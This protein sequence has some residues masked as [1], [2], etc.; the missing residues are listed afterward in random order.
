MMNA[1]DKSGSGGRTS[2]WRIRDLIDLEYFLHA[3]TAVNGL[4]NG[5]VSFPEAR[6]IYI[7]RLQHLGDGGSMASRRRLIRHW[8]D[9]RRGGETG[10]LPGSIHGEISR[11]CLAAAAVLGLFAGIS[12]A[13]ALL[14]YS[15][16]RPLNVSVYM[17]WAVF[18]QM[19]ILLLLLVMVSLRAGSR[20]LARSSI[21]VKLLGRML[22]AA[23]LKARK[24][25]AEHLDGQK[26]EAVSAAVGLFRGRR[27]IYGSLFFWPVF[28]LTQAFAVCF[29]VG[30]LS[31]T[32]VKLS[33]AD[34]AFGWQSTF[35]VSGRAVYGLVEALA[36]PWRWMVPPSLA[37]PSL[38]AIEGSRIVLKEGI[39]SLATG[40]LVAWWPF[41]CLSVLFYGL[42][43]R[44]V[45]LVMGIFVQRHLLSRLRFDHSACNRLVRAMTSPAFSTAG[46]PPASPGEAAGEPVSSTAGKVDHDQ[47]GFVALVPEDIG[48]AAEGL[49]D[50]AARGLSLRVTDQR[51]IATGDPQDPAVLDIMAEIRKDTGVSGVLVLQEAWQPPILENLNFL[52]QLRQ[53]L[54]ARAGIVVGLIGKPGRNTLFTPPRD[55]DVR[56]W[57]H[58]VDAL[59]DPYLEVERLVS[60]D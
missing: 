31:A 19:V 33:G 17:G 55:T 50:I 21:L 52:K 48:G 28:L 30:L 27:Q 16:A 20:T 35:Q 23:V 10:P 41:L 60:H 9:I 39:A 36:M 12:L 8:L 2:R 3:D 45:L 22:S 18:S 24:G 26:R 42:L 44:L 7:D 14:D 47:G 58:R 34:V 54:G 15:G 40:D 53:R 32:L 37:H 56:I 49:A 5:A 57:K 29:N 11:V 1:A 25:A 59:A 38:A 43:P 51:T 46:A 6:N 13:M 4:D